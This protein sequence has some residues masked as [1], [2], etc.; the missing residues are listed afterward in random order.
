[1]KGAAVTRG[2]DWQYMGRHRPTATHHHIYMPVY[3]TFDGKAEFVQ[4][5]VAS[6]ET[7]S[8]TKQMGIN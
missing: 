6:P 8:N 5:D 3:S 7:N 4:G 2:F 1:M